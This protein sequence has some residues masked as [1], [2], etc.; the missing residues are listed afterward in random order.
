MKK[1]V[2]LTIALL[3]LC[4]CTIYGP[5]GSSEK[6]KRTTYCSCYEPNPTPV[7]DSY[8]LDNTN[9]LDTKPNTLR[10]HPPLREDKD[11]I[12]MFFDTYQ[13][14]VSFAD[15]L[16]AKAQYNDYYVTLT[17]FQGLKED[18]FQS[19]NLLLTKQIS[20]GSGGDSLYFDNVY[21]K[22]NILYMHAFLFDSHSPGASGKSFTT[23]I[24]FAAGYVWLDKDITF[25]ESIILVDQDLRKPMVIELD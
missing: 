20:L 10:S 17:F 7:L 3:S 23:D 18:D 25:N 1:I 2:C 22:N 11:N 14:A 19:K 8:G 16:E 12:N 21:L 15:E 13:S 9:V 6:G 24:V 5:D 4:S